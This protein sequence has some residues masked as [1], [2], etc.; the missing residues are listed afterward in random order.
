[1]TQKNISAIETMQFMTYSDLDLYKKVGSNA[2]LD[3]VIAYERAE[4]KNPYRDPT[5]CP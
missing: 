2:L 5:T 3:R 4:K 1:M